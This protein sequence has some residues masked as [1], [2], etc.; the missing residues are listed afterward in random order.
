MA[1]IINN[2]LSRVGLAQKP[3]KQAKETAADTTR[4]TNAFL[5]IVAVID[6]MVAQGETRLKKMED[7]YAVI[8][9]L[10]DKKILH[11][12]KNADPPRTFFLYSGANRIARGMDVPG[13]RVVSKNEAKQKNMGRL[14]LYILVPIPM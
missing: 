11:I 6:D 14:R 8:Y 3:E 12:T 7:N 1:G 5:T 10:G 2:L 9:M 13:L 4:N